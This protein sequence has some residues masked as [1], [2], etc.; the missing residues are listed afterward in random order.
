MNV[1]MNSNIRAIGMWI[2]LLCVIIPM[3]KLIAQEGKTT[4]SGKSELL[5]FVVQSADGKGY[6]VPGKI[7]TFSD[8]AKVGFKH[9]T[10]G[11][12]FTNDEFMYEMESPATGKVSHSFKIEFFPGTGGWFIV[13]PTEL[14]FENPSVTHL[15]LQKLCQLPAGK[16]E[17]TVRFY[18]NKKLHSEGKITYIS[19]GVNSKYKKIMAKFGNLEEA[20]SE[21]DNARRLEDEKQEQAE[22]EQERKQNAAKYFSVNIQSMNP[23]QTVYVVQ[24]HSGNLK[25]EVQEVLPKKTITLELW[26]GS[27]YEIRVYNQGQSIENARFVATVDQSKNGKTYTV[28]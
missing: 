12:D 3:S 15:F 25:K 2:L 14:Y 18:A 7:N 26:R 27:T 20:M 10:D 17:L 28:K 8:G 16:T 4:A 22:A 6:T 1:K 24:I 5:E 9:K 13:D 21:A 19:D 11:F 23:S